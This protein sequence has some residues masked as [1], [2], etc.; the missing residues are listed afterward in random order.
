MGWFV[1][2]AKRGPSAQLEL[3]ALLALAGCE[4]DD[5]Y[6]PTGTWEITVTWTSGTCAVPRTE[7]EAFLV[8]RVGDDYTIQ[9]DRFDESASGRFALEKERAVV[10]VTF[11][12][13]DV[14]GDGGSTV[15]ARTI[16]ASAVI[17]RAI[18]GIVHLS[19]VGQV[20]CEHD[21]VLMG[22]IQ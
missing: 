9:S 10:S 8:A 7:P 3:V 21:G 18:S 6:D 19:I 22:V 20:N 15:A 14:L 1:I 13:A 16:D 2:R 12:N 5:R 11:T 4:A 17:T